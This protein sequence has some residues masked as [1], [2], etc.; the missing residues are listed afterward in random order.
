M[1][2]AISLSPLTMTV[3]MMALTGN[4]GFAVRQTY[5]NGCCQAN[6]DDRANTDKLSF[7]HSLLSHTIVAESEF[8]SKRFLNPSVELTKA[9]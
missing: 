3:A 7:F 6:Q 8:I 1:I 5:D 4:G 9:E 2:V